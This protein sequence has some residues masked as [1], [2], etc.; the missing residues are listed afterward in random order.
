MIEERPVQNQPRSRWRLEKVG[1][2]LRLL[3]GPAVVNPLYLFHCEECDKPLLIAAVWED[4][5]QPIGDLPGLEALK[6][7]GTKIK[8]VIA[9]VTPD[10]ESGSHDQGV[11]ITRSQVYEP[12]HQNICWFNESEVYMQLAAIAERHKDECQHRS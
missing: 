9:L 11:P 8:T 2:Q 12:P 5:G 6:Q 4:E 7:L 10:P 1:H 3:G